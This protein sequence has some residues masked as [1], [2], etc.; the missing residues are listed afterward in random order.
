MFIS[1]LRLISDSRFHIMPCLAH[2]L[3]LTLKD[4]M[5]NPTADSVITNGRK[6][7]HVVG[8]SSVLMKK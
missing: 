6:L 8:K 7:V 4:A 2:T 5:K 1:Y 3:Q